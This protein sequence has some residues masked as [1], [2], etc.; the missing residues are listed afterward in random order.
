MISN[1]GARIVRSSE[2]RLATRLAQMFSRERTVVDTGIR[3][4][5]HYNF[6]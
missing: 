1:A 6:K 4:G 5:R 2:H 3:H